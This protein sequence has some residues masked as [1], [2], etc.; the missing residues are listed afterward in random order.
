MAWLI[1]AQGTRA[2][3]VAAVNAATA[4]GAFSAT[5]LTN[6]KVYILAQIASYT[7][8]ADV[9]FNVVASGHGSIKGGN[10]SIAVEP[11]TQTALGVPIDRSL[12]ARGP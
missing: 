9:F 3:V 6:A 8:S 4:E 10:V 5:I 1:Q 11:I 2:Q 7:T 12:I